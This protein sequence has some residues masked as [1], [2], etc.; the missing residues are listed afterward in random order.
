MFHWI[1][2]VWVYISALFFADQPEFKGGQDNL[3]LFITR[4]MIYPEYS[5]QNC[6]QGIIQVSF[7]LNKKGKVSDSKVQKGYGIDLDKEALRIVRLT[8]GKWTVPA[9]HDTTTYLVLPINFSLKDYKCE[10]RPRENIN[11]A[12]ANYKARQDLTRAV[13]N[14]YNKKSAGNYNAEDEERI[15]QLKKELG[16]NDRYVLRLLR[17]A[18]SE[19]KQGDKESACEDFHLVRGLGSD[20]ADEYI[21]QS[22]K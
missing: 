16:Y 22:C 13:V 8:S 15:L 10:Q 20:M 3:S 14:F 4:T 7:K 1:V 5:K 2:I 21:A 6:V 19:L 17:Q 18:E 12:I 9:G 11:H